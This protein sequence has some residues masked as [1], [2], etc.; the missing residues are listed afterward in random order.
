MVAREALIRGDVWMASF[1]PTVGTEIQKTRPCVVISPDSMNRQL[2]RV[3]VAPL[4]SGSHHAPFRV[5]TIFAGKQGRILA[6]QVRTFN[7]LRLRKRLGAVD[8]DTLSDL[9]TIL[10]EMFKP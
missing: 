6:D 10:R 3:I 7:R 8:A 2:R 9:L 1:D 4:T 5:E